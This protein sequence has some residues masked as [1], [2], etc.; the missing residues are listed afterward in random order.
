MD[1]GPN[2]AEWEEVLRTKAEQ[3]TAAAAVQTST[4]AKNQTVAQHDCAD[5]P[6]VWPVENPRVPFRD[7]REKIP[8]GW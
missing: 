8:G 1:L 2:E 6:A 4:A 5:W 3:R 7:V